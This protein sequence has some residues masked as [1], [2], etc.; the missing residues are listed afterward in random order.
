MA[1]KKNRPQQSENPSQPETAPKPFYC[2]VNYRESKTPDLTFEWVEISPDD[3]KPVSIR[4][5]EEQGNGPAFFV[6]PA[7]DQEDIKPGDGPICFVPN[8]FTITETMT[9]L[10]IATASTRNAALNKARELLFGKFYTFDQF[11]HRRESAIRRLG[12]SPRLL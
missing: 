5:F 6:H 10:R 2:L 12:A 8:R 1:R 4:E 11:L 7:L 9:G 3:A